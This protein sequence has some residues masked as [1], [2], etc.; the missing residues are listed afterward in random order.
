LGAG[1]GGSV[2]AGIGAYSAEK[3]DPN[4]LR[5]TLIGGATGA[6]IGAL[7]GG[8]SSGR[9]DTAALREA[10]RSGYDQAM[11]LASKELERR[12]SPLSTPQGAKAVLEH[13][14]E[15]D[16]A[17]VLGAFKTGWLARMFGR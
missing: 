13:L 4:L 3:N 17:E 5:K 10:A 16:R 7:A 12:M 11:A 1:I 15:A 9:A 2:G 8:L 14:S 6:G